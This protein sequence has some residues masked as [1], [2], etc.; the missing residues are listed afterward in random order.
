MLLRSLEGTG[1]RSVGR[2][3]FRSLLLRV[4]GGCLFCRAARPRVVAVEGGGPR[5]VVA[6]AQPTAEIVDVAAG[7]TPEQIA[8]LVRLA[9]SERVVAIDDRAV[10]DDL[11]AGALLATRDR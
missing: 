6:R 9:P 7:V 4:L 11:D 1:F 10:A 2:T 3:G 8:A 5:P